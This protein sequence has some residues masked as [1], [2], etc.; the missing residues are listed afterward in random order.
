MLAI[1]A[2]T[3]MGFV[4][5]LGLATVSFVEVFLGVVRLLYA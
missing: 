5:G 2:N 4:D 3:A 1:A